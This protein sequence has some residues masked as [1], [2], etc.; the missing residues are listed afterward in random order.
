MAMASHPGRG[1]GWLSKPAAGEDAA[2]AVDREELAGQLAVWVVDHYG[3]G[4]E[5]TELEPMPGHAGLSFGFTAHPSDGTPDRLVMRMPPKGVR[6]RGNTDVIRQ[7]PLLEAMRRHGVKVAEV[8]WWSEDERWFGVP[9]FMVERLPGTTLNLADPDPSFAPFDSAKASNMFGQAI[10]ELVDIHRLDW[11]RELSDWEPARPLEEEILFWDPILPKAAQA[12]WVAMGERTRDLLLATLPSDPPVGV[13][14]GD[15]QTSNLLFDHG[16]LVAVIDWEIAGIG[17]QLLDLGWLIMMNDG[18]SWYE[19]RRSDA[20][21][22]FEE[23]VD[24]YAAKSG[25][26]LTLDDVAFYRALSGYRFGVISGLNVM[27]H[28]TGKR[29]DPLWE[30]IALSVPALF[31]RAAELLGG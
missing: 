12:E 7:V 25:T 1:S 13:F 19:G 24:R 22:P 4:A 27:L 14:H 20:I 10:D 26:P 11:R 5:V 9:Y 2:V 23:M 3:A 21:P 30:G 8:R 17:A 15:F 6:R 16:R 31:G 18:E 29:H 28:R